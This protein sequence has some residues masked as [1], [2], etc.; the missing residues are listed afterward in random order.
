[1]GL[2]SACGFSPVY[3]QGS[4]A[5]GLFN[6]MTFPVVEGRFDFE[7]R[8]RLIERLGTAAPDARYRLSFDMEIESRDLVVNEASDIIRYNLTSVANFTVTDRATNALL[9]RDEVKSLTAYSTTSDTYP[10]TVAERA[11]NIRLVRS[12]ADLM[13]T[14]MS[15][16]AQDWAT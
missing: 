15:V 11:A 9:F 2:L 4:A 10:T 1:L 5:S 13:V 8:E 14:R 12:L 7:L 6:Q 3:K 16:T